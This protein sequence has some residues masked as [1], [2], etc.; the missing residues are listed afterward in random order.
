MKAFCEKNKCYRRWSKI[1]YPG[2]TTLPVPVDPT[3]GSWPLYYLKRD[4]CGMFT[5][6]NGNPAKFDIRSPSTID[7]CQE[8]T[9]VQQTLANLTAQQKEIAVYWS[10]GPATNQWTPIIDI[11]INT[12][13]LTPVRAARVLAA[14]Q[15]GIN[16]AFVVCWFY[17]YLWNVARPVQLDPSLITVVPTPSFPSYPS[18]HATMAGAA[19]VIL[20]YFF[21]PESQRLKELAEECAKSRLY[22]GVHFN[23]DDDEG[24]RLGRQIGDIVV[25]ILKRQRDSWG[26][27]IDIPIKKDCHAQLPPPP[28]VQVIPIPPP[29]KL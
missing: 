16:D 8:L 6:L 19:E 21:K 2:Q 4:A 11:L 13:R 12:Y 20:S 5:K 25:D 10:E 28:Y 26:E 15:A 27:K 1:P 22:A 23:V 7:F 3:A 17:K 29:C 24:L 18:G 9:T 14:I